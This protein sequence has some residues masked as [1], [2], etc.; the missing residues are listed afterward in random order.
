MDVCGTQAC[1]TA[2]MKEHL[3][4][5]VINILFRTV[6]SIATYNEIHNTY[7]HTNAYIHDKEQLHV[8][9]VTLFYVFLL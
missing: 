8:H 5:C 1:H 6:L 3:L 9:N 4:F 7:K 2:S